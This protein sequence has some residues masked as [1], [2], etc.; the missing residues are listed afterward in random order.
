MVLPMDAIRKLFGTDGIR[1]VANQ[2]PLS[3]EGCAI[4]AAALVQKYCSNKS[5]PA[6]V[7]I[8]KDT[9]LSGDMLECALAAKFTSLG[10][11]VCL[12]GVLPTPAISILT[13]LHGAD[14]GIMISASH[15]VFSDN[16]IKIFKTNGLKLTDAEEKEIE[17]LMAD[18]GH[19]AATT[20]TA[21]LGFCRRTS[22]SVKYYREKILGTIDIDGSAAQKLT[23]VIDAANG[24]LYRIAPAI[25]RQLQFRIICLNVAPDGSN[26]NENCSL[27]HPEVMSEA[28]RKYT[29]DFGIAFD[30]DGDRVIMFDNDGHPLD[31][32]YALAILSMAEKSTEVVSTIMSNLALEQHLLANNVKLIRTAVGDRYISEYLQQHPHVKIGGEPSGHIIIRRHA[33]TGD[34]LFTALKLLEYVMKSG[35]TSG[36]LRRIFKPYP[37]LTRNLKVVNKSI[38]LH[39]SIRNAIKSMEKKI[40]G[41]I[42]VR[43]SGTESLIRIQAEGPEEQPLADAVNQLSQLLENFGE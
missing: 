9:R 29:A 40:N 41:R 21:Q 6:V 16:G 33:L 4:L 37:S 34:G 8:G 7:M 2:Y 19:S 43:P 24:S 15:N 13:K 32:D 39:E 30:G 10:V 31:G 27:M 36:E 5:R 35:L 23:L 42:I 25:F 17:S 18:T 12:L 3:P 20:P 26:I 38:A 11:H 14:L 22:G 1:G 28:L